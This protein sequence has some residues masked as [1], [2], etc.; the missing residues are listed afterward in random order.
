MPFADAR[1][2]LPSSS[3]KVSLSI[4]HSFEEKI[5]VTGS[6]VYE[7]VQAVTIESIIH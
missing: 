4:L 1:R 2:S 3:Q 7:N 5:A 6:Q